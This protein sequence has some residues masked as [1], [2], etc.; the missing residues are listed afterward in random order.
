MAVGFDVSKATLDQKAAQAVIAVRSAFDKV[1]NVA[2]WLANHPSD[3][4]DPLV[5]LFGYTVD[6]AYVLRVFF[7]TL[8]SVRVVNSSTFDLGRKLT[9]LE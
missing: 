3:G 4:T 8:D 6:E 1:E 2:K 7:E 5:E 9:G